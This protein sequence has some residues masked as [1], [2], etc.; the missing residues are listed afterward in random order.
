MYRFFNLFHLPCAD[1]VLS[2]FL[3]FL[4]F[5]M[6]LNVFIRVWSSHHLRPHAQTTELWDEADPLPSSLFI[7]WCPN[8][9]WAVYQMESISTP[10]D[11]QIR[12]RCTSLHISI[13]GAP[14]L[15]L[16]SSASILLLPMI[17]LQLSKWWCS[18][19]HLWSEKVKEITTVW[20]GF[21]SE[22]W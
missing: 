14:H 3:F 18:H 7:R 8:S 17:R 22:I 2:V 4:F 5:G 16:P 11:Y 21:G 13:P 1:H 20:A 10:N 6:V 15:R 12:C 19:P 9:T